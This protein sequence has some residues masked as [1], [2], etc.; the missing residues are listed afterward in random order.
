MKVDGR[1]ATSTPGNRRRSCSC[2]PRRLR[3]SYL[4]TSSIFMRDGDCAC[5]RSGAALPATD[6]V[7][8]CTAKNLLGGQNAP[9]KLPAMLVKS[10]TP[11]CRRIWREKL[12]AAI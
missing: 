9:L 5:S 10:Q 8:R 11:N 3:D 4:Q 7:K 6:P 12:S 2:Q 1:S